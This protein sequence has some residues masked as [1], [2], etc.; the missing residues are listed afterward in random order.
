MNIVGGASFAVVVSTATALYVITCER[1]EQKNLFIMRNI[2][3]MNIV[4]RASA[5][6]GCL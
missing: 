1:S 4:G 2:Q 5:Y 3:N 6:G